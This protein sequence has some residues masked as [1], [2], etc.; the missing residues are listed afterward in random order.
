MADHAENPFPELPELIDK[1]AK[2]V[3]SEQQSNI[4]AKSG[5]AK[6]PAKKLA[7]KLLY[8]WCW[9]V[10]AT[11]LLLIAVPVL[12][13]ARVFNRPYW[14]YP[15]A[16]WGA[17][18]W[19]RRC[20]AKM[21]VRGLE[22][23][24]PDRSY[25]L[26]SNHR[27]YLDTA[28][29]FICTGRRI[30]LVAKKELL[31]VPVLGYGMGFVNILAIDR[32]N[33]ARARATIDKARDI[34]AKGFSFGVFAEGTRAMPGELLPFKKGAFHLALQTE[35]PII[36]VAIKH[37]DQMMGKRTGTAFPGSFEVVLFPA[38]ET[39]GFSA[40]DDLKGLLNNVR[41]IIAAELAKD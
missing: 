29:L 35:A 6:N 38:V 25:V 2:I 40:E 11:M 8:W 23:L 39:K 26:I 30:G 10:A 3:F 22:N 37:T 33:P 9:I 32:T 20:G 31:K 5:A 4:S 13:T 14:V 16:H 17:G 24:D 15:W 1:N 27:S 36:P 41:A 19:L 7:G 34:L 18:F 12:L 28:A 21:T